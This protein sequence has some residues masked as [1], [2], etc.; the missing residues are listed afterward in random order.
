[1]SKLGRLLSYVADSASILAG[2][3]VIVLILHITLDVITRSFLS[4]PISGTILFVSQ[5]Y[6]PII[7]FLPLAFAERKDGHISVELVHERL[8]TRVQRITEFF[9]H[10]LSLTV[11]GALAIRN[12]SEA[13]AKYRIGAAEMEGGLRIPTWPSYFILPI[14]FAL[15]MAVLVY[16][17]ICIAGRRKPD[18]GDVDPAAER[19]EKI[20]NV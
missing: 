14:G 15:I 4:M 17:I 12:W 19:I 9:A 8:P 6:M 13:L 5:M 20:S 3:A 16:R 10:S 11:F 18:F 1:M 2:L 7:A